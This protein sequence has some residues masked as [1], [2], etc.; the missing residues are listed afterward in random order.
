MSHCQTKVC[1]A[2]CQVCLDQDVSAFEVSVGNGWLLRLVSPQ[3]C[4]E[5]GQSTG[6]GASKTDH[7][8][9]RE[10]VDG[11][12]VKEGAVRMV[13]TDHPQFQM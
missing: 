10:D 5:E 12:V 7:L 2:A 6:N 9:W 3:V 1:Y 4:M 11:K 13:F 8:H